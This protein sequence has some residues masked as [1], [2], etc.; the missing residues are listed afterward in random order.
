MPA[1]DILRHN[2]PAQIRARESASAAQAAAAEGKTQDSVFEDLLDIVNPLHHLPVV[3]TLYRA[4]SGDTI[5][6]LPKIAGNTLYGGLWGAVSA[7]A[8]AAFQ[9]ITGK[10]FGATMLALVTDE[11]GL[12]GD[13]KEA[14]PVQVA[15]NAAAPAATLAA[16]ADDGWQAAPAA[17]L[18][19]AL[20][21]RG[22]D[23]QLAARVMHA[24]QRSQSLVPV[25]LN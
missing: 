25:G 22:T 24:Y 9:T 18:G 21:A 5:G 10:D 1:I 2:D 16:L 14:A 11:L 7:V 19:A 13:N 8:D 23:T 4:I 12:D 3:G 20:A 17:S 15:D 6:M